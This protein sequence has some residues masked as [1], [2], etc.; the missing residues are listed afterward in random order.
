MQPVPE[1]QP[2]VEAIDAP[3]HRIG[4]DPRIAFDA[5]DFRREIHPHACHAGQPLQGRLDP[6][7]SEMA[8]QPLGSDLDRAGHR[9]GWPFTHKQ[10]SAAP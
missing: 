6:G 4:A 1:R 10:M 5:C 2:R 9:A 8:E 3:A 7:R